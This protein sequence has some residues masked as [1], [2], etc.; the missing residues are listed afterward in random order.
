ML[1]REERKEKRE[2][3]IPKPC[4]FCGCS[5][6]NTFPFFSDPELTGSMKLT[7]FMSECYGCEASIQGETQ[8][9]CIRKWNKRPIEDRFNAI[10]LGLK[11][12]LGA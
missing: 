10:Q 3:L 8:E 4:P 2:E 5:I 6:V 9:D 1:E 12:E 7:G 11:K